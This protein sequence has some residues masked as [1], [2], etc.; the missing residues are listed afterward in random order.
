M[1]YVPSSMKVG[2]SVQAILRVYLRNLR[3]CNVGI[4]DGRLLQ[5]APLKRAKRHDVYTKFHVHRFRH[6]SNIKL[7][8]AIIRDPAVLV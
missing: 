5:S 4:T 6:S 1:K 3:G 8:T 2:T 7:T